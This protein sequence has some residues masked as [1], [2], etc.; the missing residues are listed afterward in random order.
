MSAAAERRW[1]KA[2]RRTSIERV[3]IHRLSDYQHNRKAD[4]EL[5]DGDYEPDSMLPEEAEVHGELTTDLIAESPLMLEEALEEM[6]LASIAAEAE[7]K[8]FNAKVRAER[9]AKRS[10]SMK[11]NWRLRRQ[12]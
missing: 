10:E 2:F 1:E 11:N 3:R 7:A 6:R 8:E 4:E 9:D 12:S 5:E